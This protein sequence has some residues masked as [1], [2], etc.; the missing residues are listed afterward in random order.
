VKPA[1]KA[2]P[3]GRTM[4]SWLPAVADRRP[5]ADLTNQ[6]REAHTYLAERLIAEGRYLSESG[7]PFADHTMAALSAARLPDADT[8]PDTFNWALDR[9][10]DGLA[11]D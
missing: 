2:L 11:I 4:P 1:G 6:W 9:F 3:A 8:A 5:R 7:A 10:L